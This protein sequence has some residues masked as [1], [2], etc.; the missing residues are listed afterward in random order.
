MDSREYDPN[1]LYVCRKQ[2]LLFD[3][4]PQNLILLKRSSDQHCMDI[5]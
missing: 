2:V 3:Q 1:T 5:A 4:D